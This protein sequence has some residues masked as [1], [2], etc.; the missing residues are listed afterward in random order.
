MPIRRFKP[1][2]ATFF[3]RA[4]V[5]PTMSSLRVPEEMVRAWVNALAPRTELR[6]VPAIAKEIEAALSKASDGH[7]VLGR[8]QLFTWG[9]ALTGVARRLPLGSAPQQVADEIKAVLAGRDA[10]S[11]G[12]SLSASA[13]AS[14]PA[15]PAPPPSSRDWRPAAPAPSSG[16]TWSPPPPVTYQKS[17]VAASSSSSGAGSSGGGLRLVPETETAAT[18]AKMIREA[19]RELL[20]VSPWAMGLETL[21]QELARVPPTVQVRVISRR[22]EREDESYH[23]AIADLQRRKVDY[24]M[25]P[26]LH[27]RLIITDAEVLLLGAA[28]L[29]KPGVDV[30]REASLLTSDQ[31]AVQAARDHFHRVFEEA[32]NGRR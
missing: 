1:C 21:V 7:V 17:S 18:V 25:S 30:A 27:S 28:G 23:R 29:G 2:A 24:V 14:A 3:R 15:A 19:R 11:S 6:G 9:E 26:F 20:I 12:A 13:S 32:R 4:G 16:S 10:T 22:P 31:A 5:G 8:H